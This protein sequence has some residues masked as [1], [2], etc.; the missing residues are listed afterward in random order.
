M[1]KPSLVFHVIGFKAVGLGHIYRS[2]SLAQDLTGFQISLR[3][4]NLHMRWLN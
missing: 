2:L 1:K 4:Q 3:A